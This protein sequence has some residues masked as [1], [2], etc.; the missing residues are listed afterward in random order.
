MA[1]YGLHIAQH[2]SRTMVDAAQ[3]GT[4][5]YTLFLAGGASEKGTTASRSVQDETR[6]ASGTGK[7]QTFKTTDVSMTHPDYSLSTHTTNLH[8]HNLLPF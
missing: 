2:L 7:L 5:D 8:H 6:H 1:V 3:T 4:V